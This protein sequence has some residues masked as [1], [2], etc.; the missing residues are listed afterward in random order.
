MALT[1]QTTLDLVGQTQTI[2]FYTGA[3]MVDQIVYSGN[4]IIFENIS[5]YT[6]SKSD[7]AL[8]FQYL[9]AYYTLLVRNFPDINQ[10]SFLIWPLCSFDITIKN[11]GTESITYTQTTTGTDALKITYLP[12]ATSAAFEV[13]AA[14]VS[15]SLQEFFMTMQMLPQLTNQIA[16]N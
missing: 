13:R 11:Q 7:Y 2:S 14:P 10:S 9:L 5:G 1:S 4:A 12:I 6:L 15:I 3:T 8:W 16:L